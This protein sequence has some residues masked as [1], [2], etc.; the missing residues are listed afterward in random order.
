MNYDK[1]PEG[2]F[3]HSLK[4]YKLVELKETQVL[5]ETHYD[6]N[7]DV[8]EFVVKFHYLDQPKQAGFYLQ[9]K[10]AAI[11]YFNSFKKIKAKRFIQK[12]IDQYVKTKNN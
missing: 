10:E 12:Q 9:N 8:Y 3:G 6:M 2:S 1:F 4:T 11:K 5:L 7:N